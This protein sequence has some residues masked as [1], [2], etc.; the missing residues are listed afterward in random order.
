M[1]FI[2]L[3]GAFVNIVGFLKAFELPSKSAVVE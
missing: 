3:A 1:W 2:Q